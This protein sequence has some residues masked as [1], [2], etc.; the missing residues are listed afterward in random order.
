V[1]YFYPFLA[2]DK[3]F[4]LHF[5]HLFD[6]EGSGRRSYLDYDGFIGHRE[7]GGVFWTVC[8]SD[9]RQFFR[10]GRLKLTCLLLD[11]HSTRFFLFG[12]AKIYLFISC[13]S[14]VVE[15]KFLDGSSAAASEDVLRVSKEWFVFFVFA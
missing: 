13:W 10:L 8:H 7:S 2:E 6:S 5:F 9:A 14:F 1:S 4:W 12:S 15:Q 3:N 11:L